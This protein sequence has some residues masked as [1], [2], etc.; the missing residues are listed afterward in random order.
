MMFM[1]GWQP[2]H[3]TADRRRS[4]SRT[5]ARTGN[6]GLRELIVD[7]APLESIPQIRNRMK[8]PIYIYLV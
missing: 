8:P 1:S 6:L 5:T 3:L 7:I 2:Q 4:K